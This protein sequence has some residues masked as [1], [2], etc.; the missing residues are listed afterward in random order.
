MSNQPD[1]ISMLRVALA[2]AA[3]D[4]KQGAVAIAPLIKTPQGQQALQALI[5]LSK[6]V[7]NFIYWLD[8]PE[9]PPAIAPSGDPWQDKSP[10][11]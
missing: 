10:T 9:A 5:D 6:G 1:P 8:N 11:Q 7:D 2:A 4:L 3:E